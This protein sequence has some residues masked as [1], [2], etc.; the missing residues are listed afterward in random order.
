DSNE[1]D[2]EH[3]EDSDLEGRGAGQRQQE[4]EE[5]EEPEESLKRRML[6]ICL[7]DN[8]GHDNEDWSDALDNLSQ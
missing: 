7:H 8:D 2:L 3:Q 5:E 4:E 6:Q 1:Q